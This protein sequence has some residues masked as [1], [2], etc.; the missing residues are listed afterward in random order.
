[1]SYNITR[2]G[3][4]VAKYATE[5]EATKA[6]KDGDHRRGAKYRATHQAE[7]KERRA[8]KKAQK[9]EYD[10]EYSKTHK[11]QHRKASAKY[12]AAHLEQERARSLAKQKKYYAEH[13]DEI[14]AKKRAKRAAEKQLNNIINVNIL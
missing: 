11:E 7:I 10:K 12:Y 8:A 5:E 13:R 9:A 14:N 3:E 2:G 6:R 1:M 4:G